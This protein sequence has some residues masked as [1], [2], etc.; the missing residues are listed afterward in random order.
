MAAKKPKKAKKNSGDLMP[1]AIDILEKNWPGPLNAEVRTA[2]EHIRENLG[3]VKETASAKEDWPPDSKPGPKYFD[4]LE[5]M[6]RVLMAHDLLFLGRQVTYHIAADSELPRVFAD[7]DQVR[8]IFVQLIEHLVRRSARQSSIKIAFKA[9]SLRG[10][11]GVEIAFSATDKHIN[12][13]NQEAFLSSLFGDKPDE[14]SGVSLSDCRVASL[15]QNGQLWID[16][17]KDAKPLYHLA[18]PT[19]ERPA[20]EEKSSQQ[21]FKYDISISNYPSVRKRF[22]IKKS[23]SL[24]SQIEHYV[25]SLVRYPID[26]VMSVGDKGVITTIYE[27]Q[28][29]AAQSVASRISERLGLEK[30]RIGKKDVDVMFS[31]RLAPLAHLMLTQ[32]KNDDVDNRS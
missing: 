25:R 6:R 15:R 13:S 24:V 29:G 27:T 20:V 5:I 17:I 3:K 4:P 32:K 22:G 26:M 12:S 19:S 7:E 30:F 1:S 10:G 18:L 11:E 2:F 14:I 28:K 23:Q 31:Y 21:T 16:F 9:V 8:Y